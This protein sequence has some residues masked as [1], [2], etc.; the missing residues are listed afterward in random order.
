MQLDKKVSQGASEVCP[1][2]RAGQSVSRALG[3]DRRRLMPRWIAFRKTDADTL[4]GMLPGFLRPRQG[5]DLRGRLRPA[6][7]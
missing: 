7:A 3:G 2:S 4:Q 6:Q 5:I 1:G